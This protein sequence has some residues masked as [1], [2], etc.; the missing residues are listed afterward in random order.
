MEILA[1]L[2]VPEIV[3]KLI[4]TPQRGRKLFRVEPWETN[5]SSLYVDRIFCDLLLPSPISSYV[6]CV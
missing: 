5:R 4:R 1:G 3:R 6:A 2:G